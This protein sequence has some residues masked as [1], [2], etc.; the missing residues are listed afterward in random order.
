MSYS[1]CVID[2]ALG[3][4]LLKKKTEKFLGIGQGGGQRGRQKNGLLVHQAFSR[5][6]PNT[7]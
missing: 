6:Y 1:S 2:C 3:E 5:G 4:S 7:A